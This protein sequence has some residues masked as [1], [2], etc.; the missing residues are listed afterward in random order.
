MRRLQH[1]LWVLMA[2]ALWG[3][4][5]DQQDGKEAELR[6]RDS[7]LTEKEKLFAGKELE[8]QQLLLLKDSLLAI[9]DSVQVAV[10]PFDISGK[11]NGKIVCTE[12]NCTDYVVGDTRVDEWEFTAEG[13]DIVVRNINKVG[14]IRMYSGTY[15]GTSVKLSSQSDPGADKL[16]EFTV[17]LSSMRPNRMSGS[18]EVRV[19]QSCSS[20]FTIELTR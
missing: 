1:Y 17:D 9:P 15:D 14:I 7:I 4:C 8:Y 18:R 12:S 13:N 19:D 10:L 5:T 20:K 3:A 6:K 11:W 16:R 2:L